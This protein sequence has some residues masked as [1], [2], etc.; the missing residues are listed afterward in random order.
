DNLRLDRL[1]SPKYCPDDVTK[2]IY[3]RE[4]YH[5]PDLNGSSTTLHFVGSSRLNQIFQLNIP[6]DL[7]KIK[8][9]IEPIQITDYPL[10]IDNLIVN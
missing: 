10:N 5:M 2:V 1:S 6:D 9:F 7:L 8:D 4:Q 3:L